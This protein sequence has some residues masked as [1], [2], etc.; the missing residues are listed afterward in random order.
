[1]NNR[2]GEGALYAVTITFT[3]GFATGLLA[4]VISRL[5]TPRFKHDFKFKRY[6]AGN[7]P[8]GRARGW[9]VMQYYAYLIV[10]LTVEPVLIFLFLI[11]MSLHSLPNL[12]SSLFFMMIAILIPPL[13]F[14]LDSAKKVVLWLAGGTD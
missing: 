6:E 3:L 4:F 13:V 1:M 11:L 12:V 8:Y 5:I 7:P 9:F 2:L 14:G 10:F